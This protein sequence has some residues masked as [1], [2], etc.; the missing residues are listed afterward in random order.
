MSV[1]S[2]WAFL[3]LKYESELGNLI[4]LVQDTELNTV[5]NAVINN[6]VLMEL[7]I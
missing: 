3:R 7:T 1:E 2:G 6:S 4:Y 5:I